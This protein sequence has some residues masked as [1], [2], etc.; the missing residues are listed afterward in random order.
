[1]VEMVIV[2]EV[3]VLFTSLTTAV[4]LKYTLKQLLEVFILMTKNKKTLVEPVETNVFLSK[5]YNNQQ[6]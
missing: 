2:L 3:T 6:V 1:M 5:K 4:A